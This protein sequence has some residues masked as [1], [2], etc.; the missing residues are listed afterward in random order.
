MHKFILNM[1][2]SSDATF[3]RHRSRIVYLISINL[4]IEMGVVLV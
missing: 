1:E 3:D 2:H 4:F